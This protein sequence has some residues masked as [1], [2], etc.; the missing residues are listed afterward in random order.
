MKYEWIKNEL[1]IIQDDIDPVIFNK[2]LEETNAIH[3]MINW[4]IKTITKQ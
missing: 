3:K 2:L 4:F 1:Y